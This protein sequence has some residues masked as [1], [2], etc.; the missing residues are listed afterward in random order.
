LSAHIATTKNPANMTTHPTSSSRLN[1]IRLK[2]FQAFGE[3]VEIP[4]DR[5]VMLF[6]PNSAGKSAVLDGINIMTDMFASFAEANSQVGSFPFPTRRSGVSEPEWCEVLRRHT[7]KQYIDGKTGADDTPLISQL[8]VN[9]AMADW[10][11]ARRFNGWRDTIKDPTR[12][13][14]V[15]FELSFG[16]PVTGSKR[17]AMSWSFEIRVNGRILLSLLDGEGLGLNPTHEVFQ[18]VRE[19]FN[20]AHIQKFLGSPQKRANLVDGLITW[21]MTPEF[22]EW[23]LET[24]S[25]KDEFDDD[26][27]LN[28]LPNTVDASTYPELGGAAFDEFAVHFESVLGAICAEAYEVCACTWVD[29]SRNVPTPSDLL[30]Q[31]EYSGNGYAREIDSIALNTK[32]LPL[33]EELAKGLF[34]EWWGKTL[35]RNSIQGNTEPPNTTSLHASIN[36]AL[37]DSLFVEK[38][39]QCCVDVKVVLDSTDINNLLND[40][41]YDPARI[42]NA[43]CIVRLKLKDA[44]GRNLDFIDVGSGIGYLLPVLVGLFKD[45]YRKETVFLQQPELHLHPALQA[46]LGDVVL[47]STRSGRTAMIETHSEHLLLRLLRRVRE[48]AAA[49]STLPT[50]LQIHPNQLVVLY[51]D[52]QFSGQTKV[53]RIRVSEDGDFLDRWPRGFFDERDKE[54]FGDE[55]GFQR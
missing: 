30:Y 12:A 37:T 49:N 26:V 21:N 47:D 32:G 24:G 11:F 36:R 28:A 4:I 6:G 19:K 40:A 33:Y 43:D 8:S 17:P 29:A 18:S 55:G 27:Y 52:P 39:Y 46:A 25:M 15:T 23:H 31:F 1:Q 44:E 50:D 9:F 51:F 2:N 38:L 54:L 10:G 20:D 16:E 7:R 41:T 13:H 35:A 48:S 42:A 3:E 53:R 45:G 14:D 5:V 22:W 34:I